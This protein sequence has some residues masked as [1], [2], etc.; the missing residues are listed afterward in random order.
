MGREQDLATMRHAFDH[1][2]SLLDQMDPRLDP[3]PA[4]ERIIRDL[5][6]AEKTSK[7]RRSKMKIARYSQRQQHDGIK[8]LQAHVASVEQ[9]NKQLME[10]IEDI[11]MLLVIDPPSDGFLAR[12]LREM[13][14]R[15]EATFTVREEKAMSGKVAD[16]IVDFIADDLDLRGITP[17]ELE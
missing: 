9:R 3:R 15:I 1:F 8:H 7:R 17:R 12:K 2:K 14:P 10:L 16:A 5:I 13:G 11:G 4:Y 6:T